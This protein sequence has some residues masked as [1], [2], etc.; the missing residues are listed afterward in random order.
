MQGLPRISIT[1]FFYGPSCF[2]LKRLWRRRWRFNSR[3]NAPI[4]GATLVSFP[5]GSASPANFKN[6]MVTIQDGS[7]G[8]DITSASVIIS[9]VTLT[10]NAS[11]FEYEGNVLTSPSSTVNF[12]ATVAGITYTASGP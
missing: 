10:Y 6:G 7:T 1:A 9:G 5:T 12:S 8:L 11:N 2:T 3:D 4:I